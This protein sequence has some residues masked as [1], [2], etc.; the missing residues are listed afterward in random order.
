MSEFTPERREGSWLPLNF[1][2][3]SSSKNSSFQLFMNICQWRYHV[4]STK[5][6]AVSTNP[7]KFG[8]I[9]RDTLVSVIYGC[10]FVSLA[11]QSIRSSGYPFSFSSISLMLLVSKFLRSANSSI[12]FSCSSP[13][14]LKIERKL[15]IGLK[16]D[17]PLHSIGSLFMRVLAEAPD[18]VPGAADVEAALQLSVLLLLVGVRHFKT[19]RVLNQL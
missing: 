17:Q 2:S 16:A 12:S 8:R 6:F 4:V 3:S 1:A 13:L 5:Y 10:I 15:L 19:E 9:D 11:I 14:F 18:A 7:I